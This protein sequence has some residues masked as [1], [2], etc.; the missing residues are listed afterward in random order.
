MH[1]VVPW[2]VIIKLNQLGANN[3]HPCFPGLLLEVHGLGSQIQATPEPRAMAYWVE[4]WH[5]C[6]LAVV[7]GRPPDLA[8][9]LC[10]Y[11]G[12]TDTEVRVTRPTRLPS[13]ADPE[14]ALQQQH[15]RAALTFA[16]GPWLCGVAAPELQ[17]HIAVW[18]EQRPCAAGTE[19]F[20]GVT[21]SW[22]IFPYYRLLRTRNSLLAV[23]C[24]C[25]FF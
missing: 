23:V 11:E 20:T 5:L 8:A 6:D 7:A 22:F 15:G 13:H 17:G 1:Q 25:L 3:L 21:G 4:K 12:F 19:I 24:I 10:Y 9:K 18:Q 14:E 2:I 16:L